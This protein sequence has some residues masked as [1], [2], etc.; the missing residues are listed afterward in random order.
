MFMMVDN[1]GL[2]DSFPIVEKVRPGILFGYTQLD[3]Q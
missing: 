3:M 1:F 2:L